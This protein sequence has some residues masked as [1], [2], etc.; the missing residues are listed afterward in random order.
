MKKN[1]GIGIIAI[2]IIISIMFSYI[3]IPYIN[4]NSV[5]VIISKNTIWRKTKNDWK[6]VSIRNLPK[7]SYK[8]LYSFYGN[9]YIGKT[10]NDYSENLNV[11]NKNFENINL[12]NE[13]LSIMSNEKIKKMDKVSTSTE[14]D[15]LDLANINNVLKKY[16]IKSDY[17]MTKY[18]VDID[19][20]GNLDKI[21]NITNF[22][23]NENDSNVFS[24][25]F[26]VMN[27]NIEIIDYIVAK[28]EEE[29]KEKTININHVVDIDNDKQYE[30]IISKSSYGDVKNDCNSLYKYDSSKNAYVKIIGC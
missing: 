6:S 9:D 2:L 14:A 8:E 10:Y 24:I 21:Y 15:E 23:M 22:Y 20:D 5:F 17:Q 25:A 7:F 30:I 13:L 3:Y 1:I 11:Y 26:S 27:K 18:L 28:K 19:N 12:N 29:L 4:K 16:S